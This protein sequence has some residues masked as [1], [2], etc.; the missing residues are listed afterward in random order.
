MCCNQN[1]MYV[2][3]TKYILYIT[4]S[5]FPNKLRCYF[6][7]RHRNRILLHHISHYRII[8]I[9]YCLCVM[10]MY[11]LSDH[12]FHYEPIFNSTDL[13]WMKGHIIVRLKF[14][15]SSLLSILDS[16]N[17]QDTSRFHV[18]HNWRGPNYVIYSSEI[19]GVT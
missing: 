3:I 11:H 18:C 14:Q 5:L 2:K 1:W 7:V 15:M 16:Q 9:M 17:W 6:Y 12:N 4:Y 8:K 10:L 13:T 19:C